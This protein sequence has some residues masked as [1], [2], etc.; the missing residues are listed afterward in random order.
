MIWH[1]FTFENMFSF[2]QEAPDTPAVIHH[3]PLEPEGIMSSTINTITWLF[4]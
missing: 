4:R 2:L 3:E 1:D